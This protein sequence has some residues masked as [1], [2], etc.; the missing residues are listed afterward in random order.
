MTVTILEPRVAVSIE[1]KPQKE[2]T[3]FKFGEESPCEFCEFSGE[4]CAYCTAAENHE[5]RSH[6][7]EINWERQLL[8]KEAHE[9]EFTFDAPSFQP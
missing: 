9:N 3:T 1:E 6:K 8:V 5:R 7:A 4:Q 2:A